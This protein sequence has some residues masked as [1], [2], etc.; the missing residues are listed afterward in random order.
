MR[1]AAYLLGLVS[2]GYAFTSVAAGDAVARQLGIDE[3]HGRGPAP[4]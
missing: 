3:A 4:R 2:V 1:F